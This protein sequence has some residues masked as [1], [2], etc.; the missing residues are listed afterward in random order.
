MDADYNYNETNEQSEFGGR[1]RKG[2]S[3]FACA[4]SHKKPVF[5]PGLF[6]MV[7]SGSKLYQNLTLGARGFSCAVSG[8]GQVLK[9]DF[10]A[11]L[12]GLRPK[13]C[14]RPTKLLVKREKKPL[15]PRVPKPITGQMDIF[16][17]KLL[18]TDLLFRLVTFLYIY[19]YRYD[20][21]FYISFLYYIL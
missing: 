9:S 18:L 12:F 1:K 7:I 3:R 15:L 4:V 8:F 16:G 5:N 17:I 21:Y 14:R 6:C 20:I 10:A 11:R 2:K 19:L 13:T